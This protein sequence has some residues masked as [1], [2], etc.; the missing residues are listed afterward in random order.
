MIG[1]FRIHPWIDLN[2]GAAMFGIQKK[3][4]YRWRHCHDGGKPLIF[5]S[6][7]EAAEKLAELRGQPGADS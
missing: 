6:N 2:T 1:R 4:G 3:H 5:A 7:E